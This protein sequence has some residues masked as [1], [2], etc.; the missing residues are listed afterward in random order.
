M[1]LTL[2]SAILALRPKQWIKNLLLFVAPF[3]AGINIA[4]ELVKYSLGFLAFCFASSIGY[5]VNDLKD[6]G[7]D[8]L[9][10]TKRS[11]PFAAGVLSF[12]NGIEIILFLVVMLIVLLNQINLDFSFIIMLYLINSLLYSLFLKHQPVIE[13]FSVAVGFILRLVAG[14]LILDLMISEW[15]LIVGGFGALFIVSA[16]RLAEF[17]QAENR[18]VR[19]VVT[20]YNSEFLNASVAISISVCV[21]SYCF[22]AFSQQSNS[23]WFQVSV[24]PFVIALFRYRWMSEDTAV[25]VPEDAIL[26]DAQLI[27]LALF[28]ISL[29]TIGIFL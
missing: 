17:N 14:A 15:F 7:I 25:E 3:A 27:T 24:I 8:R 26:S 9:H 29:L 13:M 16:K 23:F 11:R 18:E 6:L 10:P 19:K 20:A 4:S 1:A 2:R 21:T 12:R 5:V 28:T 22:W